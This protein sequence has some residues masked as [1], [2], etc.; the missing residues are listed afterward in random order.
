MVLPTEEGESKEVLPKV[1]PEGE[2]DESMLE[3]EKR[4]RF[5]PKGAISPMLC[6]YCIANSLY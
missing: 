6:G 3:G 1:K 5:L 2:G 4:R